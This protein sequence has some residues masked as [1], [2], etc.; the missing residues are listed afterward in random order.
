M[1]E[2][3]ILEYSNGPANDR[4]EISK[5]PECLYLDTQTHDD[6]GGSGIV[7][8]VPR[9]DAIK[10]RDFINDFLGDNP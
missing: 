8:E 9:E 6:H 1:K 5:N 2:N 7:I 4:L 10:I 3:L